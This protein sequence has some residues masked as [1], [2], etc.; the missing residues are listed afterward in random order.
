MLW[1][2]DRKICK[3]RCA[4]ICGDTPARP[5]EFTV[6]YAHNA[7]HLNPFGAGV[8]AIA[9]RQGFDHAAEDLE[10]F[11]AARG[12]EGRLVLACDRYGIIAQYQLSRT[13]LGLEGVSASA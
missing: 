4:G 6:S 5:S 2:G 3:H 11:G 8:F 12:L 7:S 1:R 13:A 10:I 9:S